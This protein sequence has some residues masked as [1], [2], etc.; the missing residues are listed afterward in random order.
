MAVDSIATTC[1]PASVTPAGQLLQRIGEGFELPL[2]LHSATGQL[3]GRGI[4]ARLNHLQVHVQ[5]DRPL[6]DDPH[7]VLLRSK[8]NNGAVAGR[9]S[10]HGTGI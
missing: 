2:G 6:V 3:C 10:P 7:D 8:L 5:P 1:A 9:W 4:Q